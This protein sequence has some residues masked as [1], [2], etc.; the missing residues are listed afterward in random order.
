MKFSYRVPL[1]DRGELKKNP[2]LRRR[3]LY[4]IP[5]RACFQA[6]RDVF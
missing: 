6:E 3:F 5:R 1:R 4:E 2:N